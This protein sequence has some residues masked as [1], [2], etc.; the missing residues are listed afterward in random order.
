MTILEGGVVRTGQEGGGGEMVSSIFSL[1]SVILLSNQ[2]IPV[3]SI[4]PKT[5]VLC[6]KE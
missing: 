6:T 2:I 4:V 5:L 1:I 3:S